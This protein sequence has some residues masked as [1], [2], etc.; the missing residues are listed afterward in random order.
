MILVP[1]PQ[2]PT[3]GWILEVG[4]GGRIIS[5]SRGGGLWKV[6]SGRVYRISPHK[7]LCLP[8]VEE[9]RDFPRRYCREHQLPFR[10]M[11][12]FRSMEDLEKVLQRL[13]VSLDA[14]NGIKRDGAG[15]LRYLTSW[16]HN[17]SRAPREVIVYVRGLK[18]PRTYEEFLSI[19][20]RNSVWVKEDLTSSSP[21]RWR[22]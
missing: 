13:G 19:L 8:P 15:R 7:V 18:R 1:D 22:D 2:D 10:A 11:W 16:D 21:D 9:D 4:T 17:P 14:I 3:S 6:K 20:E 12:C 5:S